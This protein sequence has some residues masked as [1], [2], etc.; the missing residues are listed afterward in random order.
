MHT[1]LFK[2]EVNRINVPPEVINSN[3]GNM[4]KSE[5]TKLENTKISNR[6]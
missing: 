2:T 1:K 5:E 3:D 4:L 6:Y